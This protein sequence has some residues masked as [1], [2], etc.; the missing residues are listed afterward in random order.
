MVSLIF[1]FCWKLLYL[2]QLPQSSSSNRYREKVE[3]NRNIQCMDVDIS[4]LLRA[5]IWTDK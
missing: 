1:I 5:V 2:V 3:P 4:G